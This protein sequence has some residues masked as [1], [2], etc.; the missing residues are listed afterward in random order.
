[1]EKAHIE[2]NA[3]TYTHIHTHIYTHFDKE[4][5]RYKDELHMRWEYKKNEINQYN[6]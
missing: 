5:E 6:I 4:T 2:L 1:M 3:H